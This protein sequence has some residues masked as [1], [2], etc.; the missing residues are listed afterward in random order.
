MMST[1]T[2]PIK[3]PVQHVGNAGERNPVEDVAM[4]EG[5]LHILFGHSLGDL[6]VLVHRFGIIVV[7]EPIADRLAK[8]QPHR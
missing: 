4:R 5:P 2:G 8:D 1:G 7:D 6:R 3:L